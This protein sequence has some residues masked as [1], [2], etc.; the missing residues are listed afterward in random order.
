MTTQAT[1]P[2]IDRLG[3]MDFAH[4][5]VAVRKQRGMTQ[6]ALADLVGI[7]VTKIRRYEAGTS[8]PTLDVL[9]ALAIGLSVST[10]ALVFNE[11]ERGPDNPDLR[12][13]LEAL[14]QLDDDEKATVINLIESIL[15]RHQAR[16]LA[17]TS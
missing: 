10:D 7:H 13:H 14:N 1:S 9:R 11:D 16:R 12:L 3:D 4:R 2:L 8:Q 17:R 6:Q 5:L 15:L